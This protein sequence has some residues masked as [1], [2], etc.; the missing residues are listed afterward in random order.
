KHIIPK[1]LDRIAALDVEIVAP[2][3]GPMYDNPSF[4]LDA[5][6]EWVSPEVKNEV[7][8]AYVTM[9][10]S[11][12]KMAEYLADALIDRGTRVKVYDLTATDIGELAMDLVDAA[13]LVLATPTVLIGP[14]PSAVYATYLANALK[15]KLRYATVIGSYGWG[16]KTVEMVA[17]MLGNLKVELLEPVMIKGYPTEGDYAALDK[18]ADEIKKKHD[19]DG[20][21]KI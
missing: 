19:E 17:G 5:Y 14:H 16:G 9:H 13:T 11:T 3:H 1:H 20:N 12:G 6:K 4:I 8:V 15:P 21:V 10:G 18:L 7:I 2:S